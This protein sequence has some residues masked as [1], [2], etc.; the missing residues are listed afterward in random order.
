MDGKYVKYFKNQKGF[1]RKIEIV[2]DEIHVYTAAS[3]K[4]EPEIFP[5]KEKLPDYSQSLETQYK[6]ITP[7]ETAKMIKKDLMQKIKEKN[8]FMTTVGVCV[9]AI[10]AGVTFALDI[11]ALSIIAGLCIPVS[12]VLRNETLKNKSNAIDNEI[13]MVKTY[14]DYRHDIETEYKQNPNITRYLS[15]TTKHRITINEEY[16]EDGLIK[17][18][19]DIILMDELLD[20]KKLKDLRTLLDHYIIG[21]SLEQPQAIINPEN[22]NQSSQTKSKAKKRKKQ[23]QQ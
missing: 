21:K 19:F 16:K 22:N 14:I 18:I 7:E 4:G 10:T 13:D 8:N 17:D 20:K 23:K 11:V 15:C 1:I 12:L 2:N 9:L 6:L 5:I 3:K